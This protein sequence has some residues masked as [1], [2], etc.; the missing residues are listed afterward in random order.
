MRISELYTRNNQNLLKHIEGK[1]ID[2]YG[3]WWEFSQWAGDQDHVL[4][5]LSSISGN[6]IESASDCNDELDPGIFYKL[7]TDIQNEFIDEFR[8]NISDEML[9]NDPT[10]APTWAYLRTIPARSTNKSKLLPRSTWMVHFTNDAYS[11]GRKGFQKGVDDMD[12][13][14][15]TKYAEEDTKANGGYNFAFTAKNKRNIEWAASEE[16]YGKELVMFQNSGVECYHN[17]DEEDQ[18][19]FW[20]ED[21]DPRDI[22][23][24][25]RGRVETDQL[26]TD[27]AWCVKAHPLNKRNIKHDSHAGVF[28]TEDVYEAIEWVIKNWNQYRRVITAR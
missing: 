25:E 11:I 10:E 1:E 27:E 8:D 20:G 3:R 26:W 6:S 16:R 9:Q 23:V 7:P 5:A 13:L 2:I 28:C 4:D 15:L 22:V 18:V 24:I 19:I 12:R 21:V 17:G 14:G